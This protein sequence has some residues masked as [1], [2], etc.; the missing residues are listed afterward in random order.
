MATVPRHIAQSIA[1]SEARTARMQPPGVQQFQAEH[2]PTVPGLGGAAPAGVMSPVAGGP[3]K[4]ARKHKV[5]VTFKT[6]VKKLREA[7]FQ[8][9]VDEALSGKLSEYHK[10]RLENMNLEIKRGSAK[11][12][13]KAAKKTAKRS[14]AAKKRSTAAKKGAKTKAAEHKKRSTAAKKG[15]KT[16][17][18]EHKKRS[19]A[20]KKGAKTRAKG[21]GA[22]KKPAKRSTAKKPAKRSTAK[23]GTGRKPM[24]AAQKKAFAERM[25]KGKKAAAK[26][27]STAAKK[28]AKTR[29]KNAKKGKK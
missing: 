11:K 1:A 17:A 27:R 22:G 2:V 7:G 13:A 26:K 4:K 15:A 14:T 9:T 21:T 5:A 24:S 18:A 25:Q 10:Q 23:R 19:T 20:A 28:G 12:A 6:A 8:V 3:A 29:A 16:K